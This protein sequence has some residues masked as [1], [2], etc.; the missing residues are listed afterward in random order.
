VIVQAG[1]FSSRFAFR[2]EERN[3]FVVA[4]LLLLALVV[5][6]ERGLPRPPLVATAAAFAPGAI[7]LALPFGK[8]LNVSILSDTFGLIPLL[9]LLSK[10]DGDLGR[11][12]MLVILG[13][14]A[15]GLA[16]AVAPRRVAAPALP[17]GVALFFV[18]SSYSAFGAIRDYAKTLR[19]FTLGA[20]APSW[21]DATIGRNAK[22]AV[23]FAPTPQLGGD[24]AA[25]WQTEFWNRSISD[26]YTFGAGEPAGGLPEKTA[27][28]DPASG[29]LVTA[30][31]A[32]ASIRYV[33]AN[34]GF[35]L[36]G[37][38]LA[39]RG[40]LV[41]HQVARPVRLVGATEGLYSD[42]WTGASAAFVRYEPLRG[43]SRVLLSVSRAAWAG[44]D[45][46]GRVRIELRRGGTVLA[47]RT[48]VVHSRRQRS[49][50]FDAPR[51]PFRVE[52]HVTPTFS[53]ARFGKT[54]TRE[55]GAQVAFHVVAR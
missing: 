21:V 11:L 3:M 42:G 16:F 41:L 13:A 33:L 25:L 26:V 18:L 30:E 5:W 43:P 34:G 19:S 38:V 55:L 15:A 48:W 22:A 46:P 4:P 27:S 12:R 20:G 53:P 51:P 37:R 44:P 9:R 39:E 35:E 47:T 24:A 50:S 40:P 2:V 32:A 1:V 28:F 6:I 29:R 52:I 54:D 7:L 45:V 23:F 31:P 36:A 17:V 10:L 14:L 8:L 49:F